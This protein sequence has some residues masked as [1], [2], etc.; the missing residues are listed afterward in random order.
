M[1]EKGPINITQIRGCLLEHIPTL[2]RCDD[3]V[4]CTAWQ[5][6]YDKF[7]TGDMEIDEVD[8]TKG[9]ASCEYSHCA[10]CVTP[11]Q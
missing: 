9:T 7:Q 10:Y 4:M 2:K 3:E 1:S 8:E 11:T 5:N 6:F